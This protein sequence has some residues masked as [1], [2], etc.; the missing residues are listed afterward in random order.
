LTV[1]ITGGSGFIGANIAKHLAD[2]DED[3]IIFD[4]AHPIKERKW[5]LSDVHDRIEFEYGDIRDFSTLLRTVKKYKIESIV[6]ASAIADPMLSIRQ[7]RPFF[8]VNV[9]GT[10][11]VLELTRILDVG[12]IVYTSSI[13]VYTSKQYEPMDENHPVILGND[14]PSTIYA[15]TKL[16]GE[17]LGINYSFYHDV[18]FISLRLSSVYG[19]G[20]RWPMYIKPLVENSVKNQPTIFKTGGNMKRAFTYVK[21]VA[22]AVYSALQMKEMACQKIFTIAQNED[23]IT[24]KEVGDI[25]KEL[26]PTAHI[27]IGSGVRDRISD[28]IERIYQ[29]R[30]L[31]IR[32]RLSID[33]AKEILGWVPKYSIRAGI[34]DYIDTYNRYL[35]S[36]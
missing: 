11:N 1:L 18:D 6:H 14:G 35:N 13:G 15:V 31:K 30:A 10:L 24:I 19:L 22:R 16:A 34:K 25:M 8:K 9:E 32:G 5:L 29:Q 12:R 28:K 27:E 23:P 17:A 33:S 7:P 36:K 21:D 4:L 2:K 26:I 3:I 20:M